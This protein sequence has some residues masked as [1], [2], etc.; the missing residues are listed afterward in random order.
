MSEEVRRAVAVYKFFR[1]ARESK[2]TVQLVDRAL[3]EITAV[4]L[5]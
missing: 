2:K 5:V 3:K 1:E 4:E